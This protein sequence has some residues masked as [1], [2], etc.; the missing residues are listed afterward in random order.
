MIENIGHFKQTVE[1]IQRMS[2]ALAS[3]AEDSDKL[4]PSMF[5]VL[6]EGPI[7]QIVDLLKQLDEF[8]C[9]LT[10]YA[11]ERQALATAKAS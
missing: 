10:P 3:L 2:R 4:H 11:T 9:D 6:A 8:V 5:A 1:Q 7:D